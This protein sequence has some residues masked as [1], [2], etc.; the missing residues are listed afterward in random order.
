M[1]VHACTH[2]RAHIS[3]VLSALSPPTHNTA[4]RRLLSS[5]LH[6]RA[7][8]DTTIGLFGA[9]CAAGFSALICLEA[10]A[11][12]KAVDTVSSKQCLHLASVTPCTPGLSSCLFTHN[13]HCFFFFFKQISF[14]L[15]IPYTLCFSELYPNPSS[16]LT[17]H[18]L[19][20]VILSTPMTTDTICVS[21]Y[22][23]VL[24]N[25]LIGPQTLHFQNRAHSS[26]FRTFSHPCSRSVNGTT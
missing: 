12:F 20:Q 8:L 3:F 25:G 4:P 13:S 23:P 7:L 21:I 5:P 9:K 24:I 10:S 16:G 17:L 2:V 6:L 1:L 19:S 14:F 26:S 11:T 22:Q 15:F 18:T